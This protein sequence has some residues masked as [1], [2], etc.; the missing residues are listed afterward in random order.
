MKPTP[1]GK[2]PSRWPCI[3]RGHFIRE[4]V[5]PRVKTLWE[6]TTGK[7][8]PFGRLRLAFQKEHCRS[9][10]P[11]GS[12]GCPYREEECAI[13]FLGTVQS[14]LLPWIE[15]PAAYFV[16]VARSTGIERAD[17]K[18]LAREM[19]REEGPGHDGDLRGGHPARRRR[20]LAPVRG[21]NPSQRVVPEVLDEE[22][23]LRRAHA[24]PDAIG[25]L[26][27]SLNLGPRQGPAHDGKES[28][29]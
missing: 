18:P 15:D 16:K 26:L 2:R 19:H 6:R 4:Q 29:Q 13:A 1:K 3:F 28:T 11:Y 12:D 23:H 27:G 22:D 10:N 7:P 14:S 21:R 24:R 5:D 17:N 20:D 9:I 25:N 8:A